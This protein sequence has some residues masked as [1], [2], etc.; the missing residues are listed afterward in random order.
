MNPLINEVGV[1]CRVNFDAVRTSLPVAGEDYHSCR[2]HLCGDFSP[3][4][5]KYGV[6]GMFRLVLDIWLLHP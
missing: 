6:G 2:F 4:I 1:L 5:L 3:D